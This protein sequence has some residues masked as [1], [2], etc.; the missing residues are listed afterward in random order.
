M[1]R[2]ATIRS[3]IRAELLQRGPCTL[4]TLLDRFPQFSWNEL[5]AVIDRL[6]RDGYLV[7]RRPTRFDYEVEAASTWPIPERSIEAGDIEDEPVLG[8]ADI[9]FQTYEEVISA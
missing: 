7:L 9:A 2:D 4:Q 6:S 5:F 1:R 8:R 3:A